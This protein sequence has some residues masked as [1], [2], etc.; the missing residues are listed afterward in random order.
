MQIA[1]SKGF[2]R[3]DN[4]HKNRFVEA[5]ITDPNELALY[6]K[7]FTDEAYCPHFH[8]FR[9]SVCANLHKNTASFAIN[10]SNL[11]RYLDDLEAAYNSKKVN[12][13]IL[14]YDLGMPY[15]DIVKGKLHCNMEDFIKT[16]KSVFKN[17]YGKNRSAG[18]ESLYNLVDCIKRNDSFGCVNSAVKIIE[19]V[20]YTPVLG[21]EQ[22]CVYGENDREY[23][24]DKNIK[25]SVILAD[26]FAQGIGPSVDAKN[27]LKNKKHESG[28]GDDD[29]E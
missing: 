21:F 29:V 7:Y 8:F 24:N 5:G 26:S 16:S 18:M 12:D 23:N 22:E 15:L 6:R 20:S 13:P 27:L 28:F 9:K 14:K 11:S 1:G 4:K 25:L 10:I 17:Y 19:F 3:E 2:S